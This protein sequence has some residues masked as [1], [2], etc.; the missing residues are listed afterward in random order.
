MKRFLSVILA[1]TFIL[2]LCSCNNN[3]NS[4]QKVGEYLENGDYQSAYDAVDSKC[5]IN[6]ESIIIE[7]MIASM[8]RVAVDCLIDRSTFDLRSVI[9]AYDTDPESG[10]E[11]FEPRFYLEFTAKDS[12]GRS[13]ML[14]YAMYFIV[15]EGVQIYDA[16]N[17]PSDIKFWTDPTTA[18][19]KGAKAPNYMIKRVNKLFSSGT[20]SDVELMSESFNYFMTRDITKLVNKLS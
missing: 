20:L 9:I 2:C 17:D 4:E 7:N 18:G 10:I 1:I 14:L 16:T 3:E 11:L 8:A 12:G 19:G 15:G 13:K 5:S 6:K